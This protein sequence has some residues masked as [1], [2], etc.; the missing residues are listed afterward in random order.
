M[1]LSG[2]FQYI[3]M[4]RNPVQSVHPFFEQD[5]DAFALENTSFET[6]SALLLSLV[7]SWKLEW[8]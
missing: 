2:N 8:S 4:F 3:R 7:S 6:P 1:S 5:I